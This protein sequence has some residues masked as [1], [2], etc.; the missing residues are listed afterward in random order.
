MTFS[1][2]VHTFSTSLPG[3]DAYAKLRQA[4]QILIKTDPAHAVVYFLIFGFAR[5]Y[6]MLYEDQ[7]VSPEFA[8]SNQKTMLSYLLTLEQALVQNEPA[9]LYIA[10]NDVVN[11]YEQSNKIF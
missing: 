8:E 3:T 9:L 11:C 4:M 6:V 5:T 10:L 2:A 1:D 7:E